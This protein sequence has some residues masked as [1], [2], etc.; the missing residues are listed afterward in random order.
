MN[1]VRQLLNRI[2]KDK[3]RVIVIGDAILDVWVYGTLEP[4]QDQCQKLV[5][6]ARYTSRGGAG[7]ACE[8]IRHWKIKTQ[9]YS[10][11]GSH[12]PVKVRFVGDD[13]KFT[14][15]WDY[16][17]PSL[18]VDRIGYKPV[19]D[20]TLRMCRCASGVLLSD[21]D[22]GFLTPEF[23]REVIS[24]CNWRN[25]PCVADV[26]RIPKIYSGAVIKCNHQYWENHLSRGIPPEGS[27][28]L[29]VTRGPK[30]PY[31]FETG[32]G[33]DGFSDGKPVECINHVGAGDCFAAHL[34]LALAYGFTLREAAIIAHSAGRV[35][36]QHPHN[37]PPLPS[38]VEQDLE[39]ST[40]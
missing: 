5:E 31:F 29:V 15:R 21:Y 12:Q 22:K 18:E 7:N 16:E 25:I 30:A 37:R 14:L 34:T 27:K 9:L 23:I 11:S 13:S 40:S 39:M 33:T 4:C 24:I 32:K 28:A 36:V 8:S 10:F 38:E 3:K 20:S 26:K 17:T 19:Y 35:Y 1:L 2:S 6:N